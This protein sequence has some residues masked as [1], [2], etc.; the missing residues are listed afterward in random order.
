MSARSP[1][2]PGYQLTLAWRGIRRAGLTSLLIVAGLSLSYATLAMA[3][4]MTAAL[5]QPPAAAEGLFA[6]Q[7]GRSGVLPA[8]S[9]D[10]MMKRY[11][12]LAPVLMG[13]RD[14]QTLLKSRIP[15]RQTA[16]FCA[17]HLVQPSGQPEFH[18][19]VR[20]CSADFFG[21]F[22]V[23]FQYGGPWPMQGGSPQPGVVIDELFNQT[24][25]GGQNSVGRTLR[26]QGRDFAIT[27]VLASYHP[28]PRLYD[29]RPYDTEL[30][31]L[32]LPFE[33]FQSLHSRP[34]LRFQQA[35]HGQSFDALLVSQDVW[36]QL[37]VE[38]ISLQQQAAYRMLLSSLARAETPFQAETLAS[39]PRLYSV[40]EWQARVLIAPPHF[41][42]IMLLSV[43]F[44]TGCYLSLVRLLLARFLVQRQEL[45]LRR[46]L[47]AS[48]RALFVSLLLEGWLLSLAGGM[49]G[50]L[51]GTLIAQLL[52][53][54]TPERSM[55]FT[56]GPFLGALLL[57]VALVCGLVFSAY[58]AWRIS[59]QPIAILGKR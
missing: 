56:P 51:T 22:G 46:A 5:N 30:Q 39:M 16:T 13:F 6:V 14:A 24:L 35:P 18:T 19:R 2:L 10:P 36:I 48:R 4:A 32:Y 37:W 58:P 42:L 12:S 59:R 26:I 31:S 17:Q 45:A 9:D 21:L 41:R 7:L 8:R 29:L 3:L 53:R 15:T 55:P 57:G 40:P 1:F 34:D 52:S 25:F 27:G 43:V 54:L 11:A 23:P 49:G 47:G 28:F 33:A 20:F 38:L 50:V 44:L